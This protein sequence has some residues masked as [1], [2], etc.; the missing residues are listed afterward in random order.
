[1]CWQIEVTKNNKNKLQSILISPISV[2]Y[3][4]EWS[5]AA[6]LELFFECVIFYQE[7]QLCSSMFEQPIDLS[8]VKL[9]LVR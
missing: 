9:E 3:Y 5:S 1:M 6:E 7:K 2:C 4:L 8:L